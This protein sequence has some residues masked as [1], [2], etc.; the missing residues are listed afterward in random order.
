MD[1]VIVLGELRQ[2]TATMIMLVC[3]SHSTHRIVG[4]V[5]YYNPEFIHQKY[6][7]NSQDWLCIKLYDF[8]YEDVSQLKV[9][10]QIAVDKYKSIMQPQQYNR[11]YESYM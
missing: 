2:L 9:I 4:V 5:D 11:H 1:E 3:K 8:I 7:C 10:E 6:N